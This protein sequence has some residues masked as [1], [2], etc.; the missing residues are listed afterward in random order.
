M[1][2]SLR[3]PSVLIPVAVIAVTALALGLYLF[4]PWRL[5]T[6]VSVDEALPAPTESTVVAEGSFISHEHGT[7]G[8]AQVLELRDGSRVLRLTGL[9]TSN[10]PDLK[11]WLSDAPVIDGPDGWFVFDD[12]AYIDLGSLKGNQGNQ[13]YRLPPDVD[14]TELTSVSIW[15]DRF[16]VSFGAAE[17]TVA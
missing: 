14:L 10:G 5:I 4:Q 3:R 16:N 11:V 15:C 13:N 8:T 1:V 9:D 7:T 12:G 2:R 6:N 17:L